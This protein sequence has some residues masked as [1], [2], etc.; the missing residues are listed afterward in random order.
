MLGV[1]P[2]KCMVG[3]GSQWSQGSFRRHEGDTDVALCFLLPAAGGRVSE[4]CDPS[5]FKA[6]IV[7]L[8]QPRWPL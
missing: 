3:V 4:S 8:R 7:L 5:I 2:W 1:I 6:E